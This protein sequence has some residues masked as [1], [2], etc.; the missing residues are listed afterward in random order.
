MALTEEEMYDLI[1]DA[2]NYSDYLQKRELLKFVLMHV[3]GNI[4]LKIKLMK[5]VYRQYRFHLNIKEILEMIH[6]DDELF[7]TLMDSFI[8]SEDK[9][10]EQLLREFLENQEL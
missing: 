1:S 5:Y 9:G 2:C 3:D 6:N 8:W 4:T 10:E 7:M